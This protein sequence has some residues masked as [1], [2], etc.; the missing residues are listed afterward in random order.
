MD[1]ASLDAELRSA[2]AG[3]VTHESLSR[4]V[5]YGAVGVLTLF[6]YLGAGQVLSKLD[7]PISFIAPI[8]FLIAVLANYILQ[9]KIVFLD[10]R[11]VMFSLPKYVLMV[12]V[13]L[14]VN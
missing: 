8:A 14:V 1:W 3:R 5:R 12:T 7:V 10:R 13:G 6:A 2:E 9:R 4:L 11:P